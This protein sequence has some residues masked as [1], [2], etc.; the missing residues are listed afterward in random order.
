M[1]AETQYPSPV[2]VFLLIEVADTTW[3]RDLI[4]KSR[5]YA[6][7]G[8]PEYWILNITSLNTSMSRL[9]ISQQTSDTL[10]LRQEFE[11]G[12]VVGCAWV[13]IT[14]VV[15]LLLM[16][17]TRNWIWLIPGI[18]VGITGSKIATANTPSPGYR[19]YRFDR[20]N[21]CLNIQEHNN[22]GRVEHDEMIPL[23]HIKAAQVEQRESRDYK[24]V[25]LSSKRVLSLSVND[26]TR[27]LTSEDKETTQ[28][29]LA[30]LENAIN[31]FLNDS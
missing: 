27:Y 19:L 14:L 22:S 16:I 2:D 18:I 4:Q 24:G 9:Q 23:S 5:I 3:R 1:T 26:R 25:V 11:A 21:N 8:L 10:V 13:G 28:E 12:E 20:I 15:V 31:L 29:H 7:A 6:S 17:V 30:A